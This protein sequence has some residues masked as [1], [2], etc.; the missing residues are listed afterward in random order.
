ML[1]ISQTKRTV[2]RCEIRFLNNFYYA[3]NRQINTDKG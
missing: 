2:T 3:I 1:F